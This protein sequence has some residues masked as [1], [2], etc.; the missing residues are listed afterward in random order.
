MAIIDSNIILIPIIQQLY[1]DYINLKWYQKW[2]LWFIPNNFI[3]LLNS[4]HNTENEN[5][6]QQIAKNIG[7]FYEYEMNFF[8][9]FIPILNHYSQSLRSSLTQ[10]LFNT[11]VSDNN[12]ESYV[13]DLDL[14]DDVELDLDNNH[15][16]FDEVLSEHDDYDDFIQNLVIFDGSTQESEAN[17]EKLYRNPQN[18]IIIYI[19]SIYS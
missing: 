10:H 1:E 9:Y 7:Y 5:S 3:T 15:Y 2:Q 13:S 11:Q 16:P 17:L 14:Y 19:I 18:H 6:R 4:F 12:D 8:K